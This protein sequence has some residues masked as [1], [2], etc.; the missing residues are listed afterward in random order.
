MFPFMDSTYI[1]PMCEEE[2]KIWKIQYSALNVSKASSFS[3]RAISQLGETSFIANRAQKQQTVM[4]R[5]WQTAV[6]QSKGVLE[7]SATYHTK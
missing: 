2:K 1:L 7:W 5:E 6:L 4:V 3:L